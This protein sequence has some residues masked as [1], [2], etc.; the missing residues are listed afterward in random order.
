MEFSLSQ[1]KKH[2]RFWF[3]T[4]RPVIN[5]ITIINNGT[6]IALR[7][8]LETTALKYFK[9]PLLEEVQ[10]HLTPWQNVRFFPRKNYRLKIEALDD[11]QNSLYIKEFAQADYGQFLVQL[12][13]SLAQRKVSCLKL[14]ESSVMPYIDCFLGHF[15]P[16]EL[17]PESKVIICDFDKTLLETRYSTPKE[18]WQSLRSPLAKFST[19]TPSL[20][21][22][23]DYVQHG[24]IPFIVS[25]SPHFYEK[26][27]CDWLYQH[28]IFTRNIFLKDYRKIFSFTD[29]ELTTKDIKKQGFYKL[30]HLI[31]VLLMCQL[32]STVVLMGDAFE[33]DLVIYLFLRRLLVEKVDPYQLL[34][35]LS[36]RP[37]FI[38]NAKQKSQF[39]LKFY[40]LSAL[41]N[42]KNK[43]KMSIFIRYSTTMPHPLHHRD[44][45]DEHLQKLMKEVQFYQA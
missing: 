18:M 21:L 12:P 24:Y 25:A 8:L 15:F 7:V 40:Q 33:S 3:P 23:K 37:E 43:M 29:E 6:H 41:A 31:D 9:V 34:K 1:F 11:K 10:E 30:M 42:K 13:C 5:S 22:L 45:Q 38:L 27:I 32:P 19:I 16:L 14:Y 2:N 28:Q 4:E 35:T 36:R 44:L 26:P 39:L 17:T 20:N